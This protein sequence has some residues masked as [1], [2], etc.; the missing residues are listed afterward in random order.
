M[1]AGK[2]VLFFFPLHSC[3]CFLLVDVRLCAMSMLFTQ[4]SFCNIF[5]IAMWTFYISIQRKRELLNPP[6]ALHLQSTHTFTT[7]TPPTSLLVLDNTILDLWLL[8]HFWKSE[9]PIQQVSHLS[10]ILLLSFLLTAPQ[11][12]ICIFM[13]AE[14]YVSVIV[15]MG[16]F[17]RQRGKK[18]LYLQ[19][20]ASEKLRTL[21]HSY[22][23]IFVWSMSL[24]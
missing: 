22:T 17:Q 23:D 21:S 16:F 2:C 14:F 11:N 1:L 8:G 4:A 13:W 12:V 24:H 18:R 20:L 7:Q 15:L 5:N 9:A 3:V 6:Q 10:R 19:G